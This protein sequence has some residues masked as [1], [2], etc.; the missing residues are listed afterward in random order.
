MERIG[1]LCEIMKSY[2]QKQ[3]R[4]FVHD[5]AGAP[6]LLHYSSD[7]TPLNTVYR[8]QAKVKDKTEARAGRATQEYLV[9]CAFLRRLGSDG[10]AR[11]MVVLRDSLPLTCGKGGWAL[12]GAA[13]AFLPTLREMEHRGLCIH[14]YA[15][16]RALR[17]SLS[18]TFVQL[19]KLLAPQYGNEEGTCWAA[20][21]WT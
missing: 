3:A 6:L 2:M 18:R 17:S 8:F 13:R 15:F 11:S 4:R 14:H 16:D 21:C 9:Q 1:R 20:T 7:G 5:V 12:F 10:V 19:H